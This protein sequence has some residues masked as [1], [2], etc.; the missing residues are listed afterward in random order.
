MRKRKCQALR[1]D[2]DIRPENTFCTVHWR[3]LPNDLK[4]EMVEEYVSGQGDD[5][6]LKTKQWYRLVNKARSLIYNEEYLDHEYS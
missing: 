3:M 5:Y 4:T 1:C 6:K 2:D